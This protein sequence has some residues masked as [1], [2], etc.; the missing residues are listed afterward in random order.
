MEEKKNK[1]V[2]EFLM[3]TLNGMAY[4]LFATLIVGTIFATF[5][6][7]FKDGASSNQ[8]CNFM[9]RIF[10]DIK[11]SQSISTV[12]KNLTGAGIGVGIALSLKF[13]PLKT[14][15]LAGV[16]EL[17][18][19][20]SISTKFITDPETVNHLSIS[21]QIGDPLSIYLVC[22]SIALLMKYVIRKKTPVDII[23]IPLFG[24]IF[25]T[26][27]SLGIRYPA[28][29]VTYAIQW[30]VG[31]GTKA[32][33]FIA[34]IIV[35]VLMGMAL[36]APISSAAIAAMIFVIND[37]TNPDMIPG[38]MLAS[39]AAVVGCSTQMIGFAVQSRKDNNVGTVISIGIGTS[40]L[41]FK[42]ILKKPTIWLPTIIASA[43]LGPISTCWLELTCMGASAG[44][45]TAGLVGQI[46]TIDSMGV[47]NWQ[48]WVGIFGLMIILPGVLVF[49][50]DLLFRKFGWI[51]EGDLKV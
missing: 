3:K 41:Q 25:A 47:S 28:T 14:I 19:C 30:L 36:T 46:G 12:L 29:T 2:L 21:F 26:F 39:G 18:A 37:S 38:L 42:N 17:A 32:V 35:S 10:G 5:G 33:P 1:P 51:K 40:M 44:M 48:V 13:D 7:F 11:G 16:G 23:I 31:M 15:V 9:Y 6:N 45:G 22:I 8:F 43:I 49:F 50:I 34:G 20:T 4:G 27:L 24:V